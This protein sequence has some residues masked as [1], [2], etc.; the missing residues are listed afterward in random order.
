MTAQSSGRSCLRVTCPLVA[1]SSLEASSADALLLP[2]PI[3]RRYPRLVPVEAIWV[4]V[5]VFSH[6]NRAMCLLSIKP[7]QVLAQLLP[8]GNVI[9]IPDGHL[10]FSNRNG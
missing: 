1:A 10:P 7:P 6:S 2:Y 9:S 8:L 3:C 4:S 5:A